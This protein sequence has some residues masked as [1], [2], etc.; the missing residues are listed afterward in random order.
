MIIG[1][2]ILVEIWGGVR[3]LLT[4]VGQ[5]LKKWKE[6]LKTDELDKYDITVANIILNN[7]EAL[8]EAGGTAAGKRISKF[9]ELVKVKN[10]KC[11][12]V[13]VD[14]SVG[15]I[16]QNRRIKRINTLEVDS[17]RGFATSR[18]FDL[19]KQYVLLYG[20]NGSGKTSFSEALEYGLLGNI[21]EAGANNIKLATYIKNTSTKKGLA[22]TIHCTFDDGS[23]SIAEE[24][25]NAYRFAFV[26]KNRITDFSHIS[27]LNSKNQS[28]R[29]AALFGL[30]E[31][32]NFVQGFSKNC[33]EKY[34]PIISSTEQTFKEQQAVRDAKN[35]E[36]TGLRED[37]NKLQESAKEIIKSIPSK[38]KNITTLQQA[39]DYYDNAQTGV[40]TIKIQNKEKLTVK[41]IAYDDYQGVKELC[42]EVVKNFS[43]IV[44]QREELSNKALEINYKQLFE[45]ISMLDE[46]NECPACGTAIS[47]AAR[48]PY[49]YAKA[50]LNEYEEI[51]AIKENIHNKA[52]ECKTSI[53]ELYVILEKNNELT[54]IL[55]DAVIHSY[56]KVAIADIEKMEDSAKLWNDLALTISRLDDENIKQRITNHNEAA[57]KK[58]GA[59]SKDIEELKAKEKALVTLSTQ[60]AEKKK[61]VSESESLI[62]DFDKKSEETLLKIRREKEQADYNSKIIGAYQRIIENLS[63]YAE[64]LP[65]LIAQDLEDRIVNYYNVIN[66]GDADFEMLSKISLPKGNTN[67]IV[68][69]FKDGSSSEALQVLSEGHIKILGLSILLA[70]ANKDKLN[71]IIFDDIVNAIDDEHRN[72]VADLLMKHDDFKNVQIILSTHG[73]QFVMKLKDRLGSSRC[74]KD[75]VIYKF[76]PADSLTERGVIVEYSDAKTPI[77]AAQ[78]KYNDNELKDAASKCRQA[79]ESISYNLWGKISKTADGQISVAMRTPQSQPD[80]HSIVEALIKKSKKISGMESITQ[81][82][83]TIKQQDNWRVLNKGTH[84]EDEQ[85]EFD[86]I[87]V[88]N[89]L[90]VLTELDNQVRDLKIQEKVG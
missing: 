46:K 13:L 60:L 20:P 1:I 29:M 27:S 36:L 61:L 81:N 87:D 41:L 15:T 65:E 7:Y 38:E 74:N 19:D 6:S 33:D 18:K 21:E 53:D 44:S 16:S 54:D 56:D 23:E 4:I 78:K 89:V 83:E 85:P 17:F 10:S 2:S 62:A 71:F 69:L 77:E 24:D 76:L 42:N 67:K 63:S 40:L 59:Y 51:D 86:R 52:N 14:I 68:L 12:D 73:D 80:L 5:E 82:L 32:S 8:Q 22:P 31:F 3:E 34:L 72:G 50:K 57:A 66:R 64:K 30:S 49:V 55:I 90:D 37:L 28:E 25:Y 70:K 79:M 45:I 9:A 39:I 75:A 35:I 26:E 88:K 43:I 84:F 58:N 48:N 11:D 47:K